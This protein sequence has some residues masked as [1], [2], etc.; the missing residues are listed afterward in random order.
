MNLADH[1][2]RLNK[3]PAQSDESMHL[4]RSLVEHPLNS[5]VWK[6]L[7]PF[8]ESRMRGKSGIFA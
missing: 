3:R 2:R 1:V 5:Y 7:E 4:C 6:I 8:A